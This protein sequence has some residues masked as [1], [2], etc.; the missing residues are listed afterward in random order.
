MSKNWIFDHRSIDANVDETE[1]ADPEIR[2]IVEK[3]QKNA[4]IWDLTRQMEGITYSGT[5]TKQEMIELE[6]NMRSLIKEGIYPYRYIENYLIS[7]GYNLNKIR[8]VFKKLTGMDPE[9]YL[10]TQSYLDTPSTIPGIS[11]GWGQSKDKKYDYYFIMPYN[12]GYEI[13]G[14]KG[15]L[16]R[17]EVAYFASLNEARESLQKKVKE[18]KYF[19][20]VLTLKDL[21]EYTYPELSEPLPIGTK[22]ASYQKLLKHLDLVGVSMQ[23]FEKLALLKEELMKGNI[24][25]REFKELLKVAGFNKMAEPD[26]KSIDEKGDEDAKEK[27]KEE[28]L[29]LTKKV[30]EVPFEEEVGAT[31]P[32]EFFDEQTENVFETSTAKVTDEILKYLA[33][34]NTNL[35]KYSISMKS[36]KYMS[37]QVSEKIEKTPT[38]TGQHPEEYFTSSGVVAVVINIKAKELP[39]GENVKQG[40]VVFS[41]IDGDVVSSG[42]FK[43]R[44]NEEY[45]LSE[46]GFENYFMKRE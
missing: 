31:T 22:T 28:I 7:I 39:E 9:T 2:K 24:N 38:I 44:D 13:F 20:K 19:D 4:G 23:P 41:I 26:I 32:Q 3:R 34:V 25:K 27:T 8:K 15:D 42:T 35:Y 17:D 33:E 36:F 16:Q 1:L 11:Y 29:E 30:K 14:Q 18:V 45:A 5:G 12:L 37:R 10:D 6:E 43:G 21:P 40:L 46:E